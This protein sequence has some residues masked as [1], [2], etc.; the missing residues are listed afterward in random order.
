VTL[1]AG[2][3]TPMLLSSDVERSLRWWARLGFET[4]DVERGED[5]AIFW[6]RMH[7]QGGAVMFLRADDGIPGTPGERVPF[8]MYSPDLP[9]LR[10]ELI[11]E[12]VET[13]P[14]SYPQY[15][16]SGEICMKDP[17]GYTVFVGHWGDAEHEKWERERVTRI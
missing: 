9:A 11:A 12:G 1:R 10:E 5:G 2:W 3:V 14:V 6:A 17:D 15:M 8:Y 4:V 13:G 16:P 7:C